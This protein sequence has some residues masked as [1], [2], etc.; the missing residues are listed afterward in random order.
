MFCER[1]VYADFWTVIKQT[2]SPERM[3]LLTILEHFHTM[4]TI[5]ISFLSHGS[6]W[7][8]VISFRNCKSITFVR[9][10]C[11]LYCCI[12]MLNYLQQ[13]IF[14]NRSKSTDDLLLMSQTVYDGLVPL[15]RSHKLCRCDQ[16]I[17]YCNYQYQGCT[18]MNKGKEYLCGLHPSSRRKR[19]IQHFRN[20][21]KDFRDQRHIGNFQ[22]MKH[23]PFNKP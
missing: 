17:I 7:T 20:L 13:Y 14:I 18:T 16:N 8:I 10:C 22:L 19:D 11:F 15:S 12:R 9:D 5:Q 21:K 4:V 2:T 6:K 3:E 1:A 23:F